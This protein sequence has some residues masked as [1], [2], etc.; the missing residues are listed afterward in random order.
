MYGYKVEDG[1]FFDVINDIYHNPYMLG[2]TKI[3]E[4]AKIDGYIK[5][6]VR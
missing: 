6:K 4:M 5:K 2:H 1:G 3:I